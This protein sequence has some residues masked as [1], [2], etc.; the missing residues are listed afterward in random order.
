MTKFGVSRFRLSTQ[1]AVPKTAEM[2]T[3]VPVD[4]SEGAS[5]KVYMALDSMGNSFFPVV[6]DVQGGASK[7]FLVADSEAGLETLKGNGLR[8]IVTGGVVTD[9]YYLPFMGGM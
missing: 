1:D 3:L 4:Y 2:V 7:V 6:C 9:C 8:Y 5:P